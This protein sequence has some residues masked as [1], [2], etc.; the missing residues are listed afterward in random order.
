[1]FSSG[2][3]ERTAHSSLVPA[4]NTTFSELPTGVWEL[5]PNICSKLELLISDFTKVVNVEQKKF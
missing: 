1:M 4:E 5:K 3:N 2:F